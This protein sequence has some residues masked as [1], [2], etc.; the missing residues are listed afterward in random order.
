MTRHST[1][2]TL[3][4]APYCPTLSLHLPNSLEAVLTL[5]EAVANFGQQQHWDASIVRQINLA[6]EELVVNAVCYG[7]ADGRHGHIDVLITAGTQ[8][9]CILV[10]D[11][12]DAFDPF[13]YTNIDL[14]LDIAERPIGG[15]GIFLVRQIMDS[16]AYRHINRHN[17]VT[18]T[19]RLL[20]ETDHD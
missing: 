13:T 11:D 7:Y 19:K 6:L 16:Y 17:Q 8:D 1:A 3:E 10:T 12:G 5:A 15:L 18:L 14:S 20:P 2:S 4:N 9:I